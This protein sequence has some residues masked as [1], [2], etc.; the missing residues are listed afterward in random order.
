MLRERRSSASL[1]EKCA[2]APLRQH[3]HVVYRTWRHGVSIDRPSVALKVEPREIDVHLFRARSLVLL[4][5][6]MFT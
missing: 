6:R 2:P 4:L 1:R 3:E 5:A